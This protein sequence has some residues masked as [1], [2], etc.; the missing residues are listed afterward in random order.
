MFN[1]RVISLFSVVVLMLSLCFSFTA[2]AEDIEISKCDVND[3]ICAALQEKYGAD[4]AVLYSTTET[5]TCA[6]QLTISVDGEERI[7]YV[8]AK[9]ASDDEVISPPPVIDNNSGTIPDDGIVIKPGND[10]VVIKPGDPGT[11]EI[12][13]PKPSF[14]LD[15]H[16]VNNSKESYPYNELNKKL[17]YVF[18][19]S[20]YYFS[21]DEYEQVKTLLIN[22]PQWWKESY[23]QSGVEAWIENNFY[24]TT[25]ETID[26]Y[27]N[28]ISKVL[29]LS[30]EPTDDQRMVLKLDSSN[31]LSQQVVFMGIVV[32]VLGCIIGGYCLIKRLK[33]IDATK[34]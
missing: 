19:S 8:S 6:N 14:A 22:A 16:S 24:K 10:S 4:S 2:Y 17:I 5:T 12:E 25:V 11:N 20:L 31:S 21:E 7:V 28:K 32:V 13:M 27:D 15:I 33:K 18:G 1:K 3:S 23:M 29:Y 26:E 30:I 34:N 9:P